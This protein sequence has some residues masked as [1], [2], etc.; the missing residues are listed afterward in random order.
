MNQTNLGASGKHRKSSVV[1]FLLGVVLVF[2][3]ILSLAVSILLLMFPTKE[4]E[5]SGDSRYSY[6]EIID[7]TGIKI[8]SRLYFINE[9]KAE[10]AILEKMP[11]LENANVN[12]YFPDRVK[13]EIKE[14]DEIYVLKHERGYCYVNG[15]F[16]ILEIVETL[17]AYSD[18]LGVFV[19]LENAI[20]GEIGD[21]YYGVGL[22]ARKEAWLSTS[23]NDYT[24]FAIGQNLGNESNAAAWANAPFRVTRDGS[25]YSTQG[26]IADWNIGEGKLYSYHKDTNNNEF[27]T[28]LRFWQTAEP[29]KEHFF[30][31]AVQKN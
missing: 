5:V 14:F 11:Y 19:K 9:S 30:A 6:S 26:K 2:L 29:Y 4:I 1:I 15:S 8:G 3:V 28:I 7:A 27:T 24:V 17:P 31:A 21:T 12:S 20:S 23:S 22:D 16:E 18:F 13:I 10:K 25:L